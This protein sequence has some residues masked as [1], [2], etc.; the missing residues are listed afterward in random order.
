[1]KRSSSTSHEGEHEDAT[2]TIHEMHRKLLYLMSHPELFHD[3]LDWQRTV[4][5][6]REGTTSSSLEERTADTNRR[7]ESDD[8]YPSQPRLIP[9][10][11]HQILTADVEVVL[12]QAM[13]ASQLFGI[14]RCTGMELQAA[15]GIEG[16][17]L[18]F[19]RWLG[20]FS[21]S[22]AFTSAL[23]LVSHLVDSQSSHFCHHIPFVTITKMIRHNNNNK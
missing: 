9:P 23:V 3:A 11:P 16:V 6:E 18:L 2:T 15:A 12:P 8:P 21:L 4:E 10:L 20:E 17:S 1:M 19:L 22:E 14:E 13:T 5:Q 7:S